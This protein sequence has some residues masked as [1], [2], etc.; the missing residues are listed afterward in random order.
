MIPKQLLVLAALVVACAS[1]VA[2]GGA[3]QF[4]RTVGSLVITV[5]AAPEPLSTGPADFSVL[6]QSRDTLEPVLDAGVSL[7]F[8]RPDSA[9]KIQVQATRAQAQNR[10]LYATPVTFTKSGKW[11]LAIR[12]MRDGTGSD[13]TGSIELA[14][15]HELAGSY[16]SYIAFP[17]VIIV[18]FALREGLVRRKAKR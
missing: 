5:F 10:L 16:W 4:R 7:V 14:P 6:L 2:D 11:E 3:V 17:P 9:T 15:S 18:L 12:V 1:A 13:A 8:T